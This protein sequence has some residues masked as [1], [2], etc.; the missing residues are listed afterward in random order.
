LGKICF[1]VSFRDHHNARM[2]T[3]P[4]TLSTSTTHT[5]W[6]SAE[7]MLTNSMWPST[8]AISASRL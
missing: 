5:M 3:W 7:A 6:S 4:L 8:W 1:P 2:N